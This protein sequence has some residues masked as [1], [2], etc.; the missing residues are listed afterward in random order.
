[1]RIWLAFV[2]TYL[3]VSQ[4]WAQPPDLFGPFGKPAPR[5][6]QRLE[7]VAID[8]RQE[9]RIGDQQFQ[10]FRSQLESQKIRLLTTGKDHRYVTQLVNAVRPLMSNKQRYPSIEVYLAVTEQTDARAFPG[11][12]VIVTTGMLEY[13]RS[14]AALV[15]VLA[16]ELSH[17]DRGHQ[18]E[19]LRSFLAAQQTFQS[20]RFSLE[21]MM[22]G[23]RLMM[24][25]F[26]R[27]FRPEQ[28]TVADEDAVRWMMQLGYQPAEFA[29]LFRRMAERDQ[30]RAQVV[31]GFLR[32]HPLHR[33]RLRAVSEYADKQA[34]QTG[35]NLKKLHVGRENLAGRRPFVRR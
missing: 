18:L 27:P 29:S 9:R 8:V 5:D 28:E 21:E 22:A 6:R 13:A 25:A 15:G 30:G 3:L 26:A 17:I 12:R 10:A 1:M 23:T 19:Q 4:A 24:N 32:S 11:G 35:V 2:G 7:R 34:R 14:E 33:D 20:G 31:P 16:H